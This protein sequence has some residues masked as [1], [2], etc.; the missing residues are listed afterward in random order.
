[1]NYKEIRV[2]ELIALAVDNETP[3]HRLRYLMD[4]LESDFISL[5][6]INT[7]LKD[8]MKKILEERRVN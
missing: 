8:R 1:M 5:D 4:K 3:D 7:G 2:L 6:A